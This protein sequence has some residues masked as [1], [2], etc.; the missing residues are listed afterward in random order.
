MEGLKTNVFI[1]IFSALPI[2]E[3]V[4]H[5]TFFHRQNTTMQL[6]FYDRKILQLFSRLLS[7]REKATFIN[8]MPNVNYF[9]LT[10]Q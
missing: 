5:I 10:N 8:L 4:I 7:K 9:C 6:L 1:I 2:S 3:K